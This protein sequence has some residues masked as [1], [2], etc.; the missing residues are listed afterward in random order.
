MVRPQRTRWQTVGFAAGWMVLA[1]CGDAPGR[2]GA[3]ADS[4]PV[5]PAPDRRIA[6]I[7]SP[8]WDSEERRDNAGE[9]A[10]VMDLLGITAGTRVAD[11]GAGTGYYTVRLAER[12]GPTGIVFAEDIVP[13]FMDS[14][15]MRLA[16][17]NLANVRPIPGTADDPKLPAGQV[18]V[19]LLSHMYHE[20]ENPYAF[21]WHAQPAFAKGGRIGIVDLDRETWRHGTP[22]PLLTCELERMGYVSDG[23][24][25]LEPAAGYLA[26]FRAPATRPD[27]KALTACVQQ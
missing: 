17:A 6:E 23:V 13:A 27:P 2:A 12:V 5:F 24:Y 11:I 14:L 20:I 18:D 1:A 25:Y 3:L 10:R 7:V 26:I 19:M 8:S 9:A 4:L 16:G 15:Q 21:L 22:L